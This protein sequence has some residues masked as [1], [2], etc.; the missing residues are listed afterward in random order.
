M[1]RSTSISLTAIAAVVLSLGMGVG[2]RADRVVDPD[3]LSPKDRE[4]ALHG[5]L[6]EVDPWGQRTTTAC[7]W[8]RMQIPSS[9]GLKWVAVEECQLNFDK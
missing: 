1:R 8:S 2:A 3:T 7:R 4:F 9:Q 6:G 5:P